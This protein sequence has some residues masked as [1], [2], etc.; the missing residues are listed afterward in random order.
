MRRYLHISHVFALLLLAIPSA[1]AA[2]TFPAR[3]MGVVDGD[4]L[5]VM[6]T[7]GGTVKV[8]LF[9][10]ESIFQVSRKVYGFNTFVSDS[11]IG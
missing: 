8:R 6:R 3:V 5:R 1:L 4:T 11:F 10:F 9:G 7:E 2:E